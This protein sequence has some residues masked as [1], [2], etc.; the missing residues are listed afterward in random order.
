[1]ETCNCKATDSYYKDTHIELTPGPDRVGPRYRIS[2]EVTPRMRMIMHD[3][4][5]EDWSNATLKKKLLGRMV[6][7]QGWM[8]YDR[9]HESAD[10]TNDPQDAHGDVNRRASSWEVHPATFLEV[11]EEDLAEGGAEGEEEDGIGTSGPITA[12]V[13]PTILYP[14]TPRTMTPD[15]RTPSEWLDIVLLAMILGIVGQLLRAVVGLSKENAKV[16]AGEAGAGFRSAELLFSLLISL[17]VGAVAGVLAAL[18]AAEWKGGEMIS[19]FI[20]AGYAGTDF[21]EGWMKKGSSGSSTVPPAGVPTGAVPP[22]APLR[23][24][25]VMNT[26]TI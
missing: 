22:S 13:R 17:A 3:K 8:F 7:V 23:P 9:S 21:I 2:V 12:P 6:R 14:P 18:S 10:F 4:Y 5:G 15:E 20:A 19:A 16:A 24:A 11:L 25:P 1:V 26:P